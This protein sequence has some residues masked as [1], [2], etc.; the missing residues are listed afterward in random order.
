MIYKIEGYVYQVGAVTTV[1]NYNKRNIIIYVKNERD[2]KF[3][4]YLSIE[5][6]GDDKCEMVSYLKER[7]KVEVE[8]SIQGRK[9]A[10]KDG[11]GDAFFTSLSLY[12]ISP[13][14]DDATQAQAYASM[15]QQNPN[16]A[17]LAQS[18]G[19]PVQTP[20]PQPLSN[21]AAQPNDDLPF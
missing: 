11:S 20:A 13:I 7:T 16:V 14:M 1:G 5:C 15:V 2:E 4:D 18:L 21:T 19:A 12:K 9:Y 10:K 3:S 8:F 17:T 6:F